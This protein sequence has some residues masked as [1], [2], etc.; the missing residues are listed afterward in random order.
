MDELLETILNS[1]ARS[2]SAADPQSVAY[3]RVIIERGGLATKV[4]FMWDKSKGH[5]DAC[6]QSGDAKS[7]SFHASV[8]LS[9]DMQKEKEEEK[10]GD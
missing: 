6:N 2:E 9:G 5:M 8:S 3:A 4:K 10:R 7:S 1:S